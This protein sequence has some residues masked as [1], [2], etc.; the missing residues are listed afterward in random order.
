MTHEEKSERPAFRSRE[1]IEMEMGRLLTHGVRG[2][3]AAMQVVHRIFEEVREFGAA[4]QRHRDEGEVKPVGRVTGHWADL[5]PKFD[6][7][8]TGVLLAIGTLVY[9][10]PANV[11]SIRR[12]VEKLE[13]RMA[14]LEPALNLPE[15]RALVAS[16]VR[17]QCAKVLDEAA[18]SAAAAGDAYLEN[19][20]RQWASAIREVGTP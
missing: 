9:T 18:S 10:Q 6:G 13:L 16:N 7:W 2:P 15:Y 14:S 1:E 17:E 5:T 12:R 20:T 3:N 19:I 11:V 8:D 4:E